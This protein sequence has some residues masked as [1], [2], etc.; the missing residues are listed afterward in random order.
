MIYLFYKKTRKLCLIRPILT[1]NRVESLK[2]TLFWKLPIF[3]DST[4]KITSFRRNRL[5]HQIC[6]VIKIFFNPKLEIAIFQFAQTANFEK[7]Y[8]N[9]QFY[10]IKK[11]FQLHKL[12]IFNSKKIQTRQVF[13]YFPDEIQKLIYKNLLLFYFQN[14]LLNE[15]N[16]LLKLKI[17]TL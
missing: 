16:C 10:G 5:R 3:I 12:K 7:K 6:P 8:F 17:F 11:L 1:I 2:L 14:G 9:S 4:N 15:L 13:N